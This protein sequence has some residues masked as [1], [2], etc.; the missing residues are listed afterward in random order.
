MALAEVQC[1]EPNGW[2]ATARNLIVYPWLG[3]PTLAQVRDG[4]VLTADVGL[5]A[6][7]REWC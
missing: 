5:P 1:A 7:R 4:S 3:A 2:I 6:T